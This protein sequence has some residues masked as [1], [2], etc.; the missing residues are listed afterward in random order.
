MLSFQFVTNREQSCHSKG[1]DLRT[2]RNSDQ[3][4][5]TFDSTRFDS[6]HFI[7]ISVVFQIYLTDFESLFPE[8]HS[9]EMNSVYEKIERLFHEEWKWECQHN[10]NANENH[11]DQY[12]H[13]QNQDINIAAHQQIKWP[14]R[15]RK[16]VPFRR[17]I[18]RHIRLDTTEYS[19]AYAIDFYR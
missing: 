17:S 18:S 2:V 4:W 19:S 6:I 12:W 10:K 15:F 5:K 13:A 1:I 7:L 11:N 3:I 16:G 8:I 14:L 9:D